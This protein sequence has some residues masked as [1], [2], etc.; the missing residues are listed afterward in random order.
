M[1]NYKLSKNVYLE[2]ILLVVRYFMMSETN[3]RLLIY[4]YNVIPLTTTGLLYGKT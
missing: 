4:N 2:K 3:L 1:P